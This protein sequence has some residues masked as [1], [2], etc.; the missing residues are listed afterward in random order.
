MTS[1]LGVGNERE[2]KRGE[3]KNEGQLKRYRKRG[4]AKEREKKM[5]DRKREFKK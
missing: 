2:G 4:K 5:R 1:P 3:R